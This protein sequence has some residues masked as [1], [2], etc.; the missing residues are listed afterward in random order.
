MQ[1]PNMS[2]RS[3]CMTDVTGLYVVQG[4]NTPQAVP[5]DCIL[6]AVQAVRPQLWM[7][8]VTCPLSF[9]I[10]FSFLLAPLAHFKP[11]R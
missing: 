8:T 2:A 7:S 6:Y 10:T 11:P 1:A 5:A 3:F 9:S 4:R